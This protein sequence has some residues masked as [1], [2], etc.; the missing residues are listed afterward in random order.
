MQLIRHKRFTPLSILLILSIVSTISCLIAFPDFQIHTIE[1]MKITLYTFI[2]LS[3]IVLP[4]GLFNNVKCVKVIP[5]VKL[6]SLT[7]FVYFFGFIGFFLTSAVSIV[8]I[9]L[10]RSLGVNISDYKNGEL[11]EELLKQILPEYLF[12][13]MGFTMAFSF[14][15]LALHFYFLTQNQVKK[16]ILPF[17]ISLTI[18]IGA[19]HEFARGP[20]VIFVCLYLM[21]LFMLNRAI[22]MELLGRLKTT[23]RVV[24]LLIF[25]LFTFITL[26]RFQKQPSNNEKMNPALES[27]LEYTGQ[28]NK[29]SLQVLKSYDDNKN[30]S[31]SRFKYLP[32]RIERLLGYETVE[33]PENDKIVYGNHAASFRGVVSDLVYDLGYV[34]TLW[35]VIFF[36]FLCRTAKANKNGEIRLVQIITFI[37]LCLFASSFY[38]G[39]IFVLSY[40]SFAVLITTFINISQRIKWR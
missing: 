18:P 2:I 34:G 33:Q 30:M 11:G 3:G 27:I 23:L 36:V 15:A 12:T 21:A 13:I 20:L 26:N 9:Y 5:V 19:I 16:S 39:N 24:L 32:R 29:Y 25:G 40:F 1:D 7:R 6:N 17:I 14:I 4:F 37:L 28:W 22:P 31:A 10:F 8:S 38:R 35:F